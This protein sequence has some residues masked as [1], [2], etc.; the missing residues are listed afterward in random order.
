MGEGYREYMV[1][2]IAGGKRGSADLVAYFEL[3]A[4]TLL[5][6]SGQTGVVATNTL[7][8]GDSR[9][10]GLDQ[11]ERAGVTIRRAVKSAP[12]PSNS[13]ALEYCAIWTSSKQLSVK[14]NRVVG[15][16]VVSNGIST[17]LNPATRELSWSEPLAGASKLA[18]KGTEVTGLGFAMRPSEAQEIITAD[19][20]NTEVVFPYLVGEDLNGN[21]DTAA[22]RW[23]VDFLDRT[24]AEAETY[25]QC[26]MRVEKL[27]K[28]ERLL[29]NNPKLREYWWRHKRIAPEMRQAV[30]GLE[31]V[32]VIALVSKTVMP[33]MVQTGQVFSH[34]LG[35]FASDDPALL[36]VL[37][38]AP[39]TG[40][41]SIAP[42][43]SR[44][45]SGTRPP[46]CLKPSSALR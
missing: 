29:N 37:S 22:R 11:L 46:T 15:G 10:V 41:P 19:S 33:V 18:F 24:R 38:S 13:A 14:A 9:E 2:F 8:Q 28:P 5:N 16:V 25:S 36:A 21:P 32:I 45:T 31:R 17:A 42:P 1:D 44:A 27:V 3:R 43:L 26:Y 40:G 39:I 12:W 7:A 34:M 23:T 35:V 20:R 4:H 6:R 30:S